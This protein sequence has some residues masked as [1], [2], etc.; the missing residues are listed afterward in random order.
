MVR[1]PLALSV[2]RFACRYLFG[3]KWLRQE[4]VDVCTRCGSVVVRP[5]K[6]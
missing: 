4:H 6:P 5:V 3:H 2:R 1:P